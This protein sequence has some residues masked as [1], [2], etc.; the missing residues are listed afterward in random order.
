MDD[1][2]LYEYDEDTDLYSIEHRRL[3][4]KE[5]LIDF[6]VFRQASIIS[7]PEQPPRAKRKPRKTRR[8]T[9]KSKR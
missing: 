3:R 1:A 9:A 5:A 2:T 8:R 4:D 6:Y 7:L